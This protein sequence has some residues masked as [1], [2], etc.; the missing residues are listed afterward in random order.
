VTARSGDYERAS[1]GFE[2]EAGQARGPRF[3]LNGS[4]VLAL[5]VNIAVVIW[6]AATL[7][8]TVNQLTGSVLQLNRTVAE[9]GTIVQDLRERVRVLEDRGMRAN[10]TQADP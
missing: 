8:A 2:A 4:L 1:G 10:R 5:V 9:F 3:S 7:S 6:G